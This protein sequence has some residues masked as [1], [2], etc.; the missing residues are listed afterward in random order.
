[1]RSRL[2]VHTN[3][4]TTTA[5]GGA[6]RWA[7]AL[8][9]AAALVLAGCGSNSGAQPAGS[10]A[11]PSTASPATTTPATTTPATTTP[12]TAG[13]PSSSPAAASVPVLAA[14]Y[15]PLWPFADGAQVRSWQQAYR[16]GGQ[17]PWHLDPAATALSFARDFL[18]YGDVTR[19]SSRSVHGSDA[20]IGVGG[21]NEEGAAAGTAALV[22]LL[23]YGTAADAPWEVVGTNDTWLTLATPRYGSGVSTPLAVGGRITGVD[24]ALQ[25]RVRTA[26]GG[27]VVGSAGPLA[28][29]GQDQPWKTT[30]GFSA[31]PRTVLVIA[32]STGGHL[33]AVER[34]AVTAVRVASR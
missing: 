4:A 20:V 5:P 33:L 10:T 31:A 7:W 16:S 25:V 11:G 14:G 27:T 18:G 26:P 8:G 23:R 30:L 15:V 3:P 13:P 12:G 32:V 28:A 24:E 17:Q 21:V 22:H 29:G 19:V 2:R 34:F 6:A 9:T 1:M